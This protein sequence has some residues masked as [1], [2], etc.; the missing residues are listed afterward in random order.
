MNNFSVEV[1]KIVKEN[2]R[3]CYNRPL[4][5]NEKYGYILAGEY[6]AIKVLC[7]DYFLGSAVFFK[8]KNNLLSKVNCPL[9]EFTPNKVVNNLDCGSKI[10]ILPSCDSQG[11]CVKVKAIEE[12]VL[13]FGNMNCEKDGHFLCRWGFDPSE[14]NTD[15][16]FCQDEFGNTKYEVLSNKKIRIS[17]EENEKS[18]TY[19]FSQSVNFDKIEYEG[20]TYF[21]AILPCKKDVYIFANAFDKVKKPS[22][23]KQYDLAEKRNVEEKQRFYVKTPDKSLNVQVSFAKAAH[24]ALFI[25]G[26][27]N[28]G[29][30]RWNIP[31]LGWEHICGAAITGCK[32]RVVEEASAVSEKVV[33][34]DLKK[35]AELDFVNHQGVVQSRNSLFYGYGYVDSYQGNP[36]NMQSIY[37][38]QLIYTAQKYNLPKLNDILQKDLPLHSIWQDRC[39]DPTNCG[40]YESYINTF[41]TDSIWYNGGKGVEETAF[42]Y[43]VNKY[44]AE[45]SSGEEKTKYAQKA[46][47]IKDAFKKELWIKDEG[48]PAFY[49]DVIGEKLLH[50]DAWSYSI[51]YAI[52]SGLI[53]EF[54]SVE[55]L[56]YF[57]YA[58]ESVD[59]P[60][61]KRTYTSNFVPY[62][63][64]IRDLDSSNDYQMAEVYYKCGLSELGNR[65][66]KASYMRNFNGLVPGNNTDKYSTDF[67]TNTS[68]FL[69]TVNDGLFGVRFY[70]H[71]K[72]LIIKPN[73]PIRWKT[74]EYN[75]DKLNFKFSK[76][77][78]KVEYVIST[79]CEYK[80]IIPT[81]QRSVVSI[82]ANGKD[83]EYQKVKGFLT[84]LISISL[85]G[86]AKVEIEFAGK[87]VY[88]KERLIQKNQF[89]KCNIEGKII[90]SQEVLSNGVFVKSG[91]HT[92]FVDKGDYYSICR[93]N[94]K[95]KRKEPKELTLKTFFCLNIESNYNEKVSNIYKQDYL[96]PRVDTVSCQIARDC[97]KYWTGVYW[98][99]KTPEIDVSK[100]ENYKKGNKF[101]AYDREFFVNDFGLATFIS[102]YDNFPTQQ[103]VAVNKKAKAISILFVGA[104]NQMQ[105]FVPAFNV[106]TKYTDGTESCFEVIPPYHFYN[107][108]DYLSE[109]R[110]ITYDN[111]M[112]QF[113]LGEKKAKTLFIG[114]NCRANVI[115]VMVDKTK[116]IEK[117]TFKSMANETVV[118]IMAVTLCDC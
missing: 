45:I 48:H 109:S 56:Y 34:E 114:N 47:K 39:F 14:G 58:L 53:D 40:L 52:N 67:A 36:Y 64:S 100:I 18:I 83:V 70:N 73:L 57:D 10:T 2:G 8:R 105:C 80:L 93:L 116:T 86:D 63:W 90:D 98:G 118:G 94:I 28:H 113:P 112:H 65:V 7:D 19:N 27:F 104:T 11:A 95:E 82:R 84:P 69:R 81:Y 77:Y 46:K 74:A 24:D 15:D 20:K 3:K 23:N 9:T 79:K 75:C 76:K 102:Q 66:F 54:E 16:V 33:R 41:P 12:L 6:P 4:Y 108:C 51:F 13:V 101:V 89:K 97:F 25:N 60:T 88:E 61:G 110:N 96:S 107:I 99:F 91:H 68:L 50:K 103:E 117:I 37:Y 85:C 35:D 78:N 43:T 62:V 55:S 29:T 49:K 22:V 42:A 30:C 1:N 38:D 31:Y 21:C 92:L 17:S 106:I 59:T 72:D 26:V 32:D 5:F 44:L 71:G 115:D 87:P 111:P